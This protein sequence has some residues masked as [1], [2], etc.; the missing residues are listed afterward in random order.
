MLQ[1]LNRNFERSIPFIAPFS[2]ILGIFLTSYVKDF[3]YL[4]PCL[5]AF[6]TFEGSLSLNFRD[7]KEA[8]RQP[9]P[10]FIILSFLH[11]IMPMLTWGIAQLTFP[12]DSETMTGLIL[13]M[14]IPTGI[15]SFIWV[16]MKKG[17]QA[18]TLSVIIIDAL[19]A[20][21]LVPLSL[22]ILVGQDVALDLWQMMSSLLFMIVFPS[23]IALLFNEFTKGNSGKVWKPR[24]SPI[25]KLFLCG[26]MLLNGAEVAP[27]FQTFNWELVY[28]MIVVIFV[29]F[30][31]YF[32]SFIIGKVL[33]FPKRSL[34]SLT[35]GGGMRNVSAGAV[36][37]ITFFPSPVVL[38][39]VVSMLF[40]QMIASIFAMILDSVNEKESIN[41]EE[42]IA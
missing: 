10:V 1:N 36:I 31:G 14:V 5:F 27:F 11:I 33:Q 24:L 26:V 18:L 15:T 2:V 6:M 19:L 12:E 7:L 29:T 3:T 37:A 40:Q 38:P 13:S 39:I 16:S 8:V 4:I 34:V 21:F 22:S 30:I 32:L 28:I 25:S 42:L 23:I 17:N 41:N 35:F 20:P 9:L